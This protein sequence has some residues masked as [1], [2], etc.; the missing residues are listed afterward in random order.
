MPER[1]ELLHRYDSAFETAQLHAPS[2]AVTGFDAKSATLEARM[3][4][5]SISGDCPGSRSR[6]ARLI[7]AHR[8]FAGLDLRKIKNLLCTPIIVDDWVL[9]PGYRREARVHL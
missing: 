5:R 3:T 1:A 2:D 4:C 8:D 9:R 6:R 7:T